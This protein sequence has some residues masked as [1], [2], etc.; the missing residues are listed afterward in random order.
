MQL[1]A[2]MVVV[3][4]SKMQ[5]PNGSHLYEQF[6]K[7]YTILKQTYD[8]YSAE[9]QCQTIGQNGHLISIDSS[10]QNALITC[11]NLCFCPTISDIQ[12]IISTWIERTVRD[13]F[14]DG[15]E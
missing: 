3:T 4:D 8:W 7:C 11:N 15:R 13:R 10:F 14:V 5:C 2:I 1:I 9:D 6:G 12:I